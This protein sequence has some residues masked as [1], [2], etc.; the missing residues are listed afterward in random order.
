[1]TR[2]IAK[3]IVAAKLADKCEV[4]VA[5]CIGV[6]EPMSVNVNTFKTGI[7]PDNDLVEVINK[8]FD[9][10]PDKIIDLNLKNQF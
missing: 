3:N 7:M 9:L 8:V 5:Y 2:Y 4:Q 10:K 6:A 1:M